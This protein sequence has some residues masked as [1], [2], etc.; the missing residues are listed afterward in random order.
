MV[1]VH[2]DDYA[3]EAASDSQRPGGLDGPG[4]ALSGLT[5]PG[6]FEAAVNAAPDAVALTD[7]DRSRTWRQW[8][9][10]VDAL[11]YGLQELGVG[12]GDV[13]AIQLPNCWE[14][15]TLHLAVAA[16]GA[17]MM[18]IHQGNGSADVR[19]LLERVEPVVVV[20]PG[21]SARDEGAPAWQSLRSAVPSL[22]AVL[23][24]GEYDDSPDVLSVDRLLASRLGSSP[25]P[26]DVR[27]ELPFVLIPSSGTTSARPKLCL[28]SHDG[29]LSNIEAVAAQGADAFGDAV[30]T[31][32]PL[33]HL[34]GLQSM[35]SALFRACRQVLLRS[36]DPDRFLDLAR[37]AGPSTVFAVPAQLHDIVARLAESQEP[38]GFRPREVRT[39]GAAIPGALVAEV[40]AALD[41]ALVVVWG[42]SELGTGTCTEAG[43]PAEV[44][45][46]SVGRP[47][48]GARVRIVDEDGTELP[49]GESGELQY[50]SPSMF[51][52]YYGEAEL[53]RSAVTADGWLR[54][55]DLA[56]LDEDGR[57][58]FDGRSAELINVGGRKFNATEI[59]GLL[60]DLPGIG[61]L[62][63][64]GMKDRRLGELPC[65]V[66]TG[67]ASRSIGLTEVT[68][69]L[70]E[71]GVADY[72]IPL[73]LVTVDDL[74][75]TP[76]GKLHRRALEALLA[77]NAVAADPAGPPAAQPISFGRALDLVRS[78]VTEVLGPDAEVSPIQPGATFRSHGLDSIRSIRLRNL[79]VEATGLPLPVSLAFDYPNPAAVAR[80]LT[81]Q[82]DE[83]GSREAGDGNLPLLTGEAPGEGGAE[84][85]A[86]VGMACR[87]PGE[88]A[89]PDDLWTLLVGEGDAI[90]PF[91]ADRGWELDR[92][93]HPDP[94]HRGTSYVQ[95][96]GFLHDAGHFDA[97]F[98]GLSQ[99]EALATDPQQR[100]LLETAWEALERAEIDPTTLHGSQTGV[101]TGAMYHDYGMNSPVGKGELEG[102]IGIGTTSSALAGR[103]SYT[104]GFEGPALTVDTSC[105]S[106]L[107][108]LHLACRSLRSG[109]SSLALA[110]GVAVMATPSPFVEFSRLRG[111]S[112]DG[113]CKSF[114]DAADGAAWSEGVGLLVLERLSDAQR[115]GHRVLA[116]VRGTAVNQ[117]GAS[118][119]LTAPN[120]PAQRRVIRRALADARLTPAEVDVV[121][122]HGT[123]TML[124][125]P[126]EAQ[127][128]LATYGQGRSQDRPL[129]LGS[130]KSNIG[131][132]Q[133][134]AGVA[135]VIKMVL[136]MQHG[137]LP[138]TLHVDAPSSKVDW[139]AGAVRLLTA[140]QP[141]P[142]EDGRARRAGVSSFG[143]SGTNAHLVLEEA[144]TRSVPETVAAAGTGGGAVPWILSARSPSAL[145]AQAR[146]LAGHA[147]AHPELSARDIAYALATTRAPHDHGTFVVGSGR[148]ELIAAVAALGDDESS[149]VVLPERAGGGKLAFVLT[150][151]GSQRLGMGRGLAES[152]P[153]FDAALREVCAVLDP[154]L[155]RPLASVMWGGPGTGADAGTAGLLDG[156]RY[157]QPA[158]F[159]FE[160]ALFRLFESWGVT[161]DHLVGHSVGEIA[162]AHVA[163]VL[164]LPDACTLVEA[165][166]RLMQALP[167]G[168]TMLAVGMAEDDLARWLTDQSDLPDLADLVS[169]AAVN[170]PRSA[171]LS[172][173][174]A[175][176]AELAD[177]LRT[178]GHRIRGLV[179][180]HAFHSPLMTPMLADF[181][182]V[183]ERLSFAAPTIPLVSGLTGR[184][185]TEQEARDPGYWVR[186]VREPVRFKDAIEHLRDEQTDCFVELGPDAALAPMV[187]ECLAAARAN[188][189]A[190]AVAPAVVPTLSR[191][192]D[193][194]RA[195]LTAV[196]RL[197]LRGVPVAWASVLPGAEPVPLPTYPFQRQGYWIPQEFG[198]GGAPVEGEA[199]EG[200]AVERRSAERESLLTLAARLTGLDDDEQDA[201]V[202]RIVLAETG[203]VLG[204]RKPNDSDAARSF[205]DMGINSVKAIE[206]RNRLIAAT[207][208]RLP[209][210]LVFD[211][212]TPAAV[213]R[214]VREGLA[215]SAT[216]SPRSAAERSA[217]ELVDELESLLSAGAGVDTDTAARLK[218]IA[219]RWGQDQVAASPAFDLD[220]ATDED[221]FRLMDGANG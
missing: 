9:S 66:V 62:A 150:G 162:A 196:G 121:E 164:S 83:A 194:E 171:V 43:D 25:R 78:C 124:G 152:F 34:F 23:V 175:P 2:S 201:L 81:G 174:Q 133:A 11:A 89:S 77:T 37:A 67:R 26:V 6:V 82:A 109:E 137:L 198:A 169:I 72:K 50:H 143:V 176:L 217:A 100:L 14:F 160:V 145:R 206:L 146:R 33:T 35:H 195:V 199:V 187:D 149:P 186:H 119:G 10:E 128:L 22:R 151:Q 76:A 110:G 65:L 61:P 159:A 134:A 20:L 70:R 44:A 5:L 79:L 51:R 88:V 123:G 193:E 170:G 28:H 188:G 173:A 192:E 42:M 182:A 117:D 190:A 172:G 215:G 122:A 38:A 95:E 68:A 104:F 30:L 120:G 4:L 16:V 7:G 39:A 87:L 166:G 73:E 74:P 212:P 112:P 92:L 36:W 211:R 189:P 218:D 98:F 179:V 185:L 40:R 59:Q 129:W 208:V 135:G 54:T 118:N 29:L 139:S 53:T 165:R 116:V 46:Q 155:D 220:T 177:R 90:S 93:F 64:V 69:F 105:S 75:R 15:E 216:G 56:S 205:S 140:S 111:L 49:P 161:P 156:T 204:G 97:G 125:D 213:V 107:V 178:A 209:A 41:T 203:A 1:S 13:V 31:A 114:A 127:A 138:R 94:E 180:S 3:I 157:A 24:A 183:I 136:A 91:P 21:G 106:S 148:D 8:K 197:H 17:V 130:V 115:N 52:G 132:A 207:G 101:F 58:H 219:R 71:R 181:R 126:I 102:L 99:R 113:R 153:V 167:P 32:C 142:R 108:A 45:A 12:I 85:V 191:D 103:I 27:P 144:P 158:L 200:D 84:P 202:L 55:G 18:P 214:L 184:P 48:R 60:A 96:G 47:T 131:H 154:L 147:A 221:L 80:V 210:T 163:G 168:G 57:L 63:V 141:W 19:A 86:I